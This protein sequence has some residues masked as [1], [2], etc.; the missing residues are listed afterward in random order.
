MAQLGASGGPN[1]RSS[2]IA[3]YGFLSD[4]HSAALL[5]RDGSVDWW[6]PERFDAPS[7]FARLLD[8]DAGHWSMRP[9]QTFTS[10]RSYVGRSLV[11]RTTF[12]TEH[13][14]VA[15]TDALAQQPSVRGHQLGQ[16]APHALIRVVEGLTGTVK[17]HTECAP[18]IEYGRVLPHLTPV[19]RGV[20]AQAGGVTLQLN[21][22]T[23][24]DCSQASITSTFTVAA[25]Q[26]HTFCL[27]YAPTYTDGEPADLD[28]TRCLAG[29]VEAWESW[30][31]LHN[32][33]HGHYAD[34]VQRSSLVIQGLTYQPSGAVV[35]AATTSLPEVLG[36]ERNYDYR[37]A[38]LRDFT[39][40]MRA[41]WIAACPDE[42]QALF[43]WV[44]LAT[45]RIDGQRLPIM[46]SVTGER[47]VSEHQLDHLAGFANSKP[48]R[49]GNEAWK[50]RQL[51]VL[52][53]I[54]DAAYLLKDELEPIGPQVR[55]LLIGLAEQA[56]HNWRA[57]DAG[58]W[59]ARDKERPYL[60]S[61][62]LCWVALD[63]AVKLAPKL[64]DAAK[65]GSPM[66]QSWATERDEIH[67]TVLKR[68]WN[69]KIGAFTGAFES[70]EL[71]ASVLLMPLVDF[72]P[73]EDPRMRATIDLISTKLGSNGL[74]R[75]WDTDPGGFLLCTY[76]LV[77]CLA[78]A[79]EVEKASSWF[80]QANSYA[81]DLGLLSEQAD[82]ASGELLG[83]FPQLFS[84]IGQINAA[85]RL[86]QSKSGNRA[87]DS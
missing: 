44:A 37:Y 53:E 56:K 21:A 8:P 43:Q 61:K 75:R 46:Y 23:P 10:Q 50:Q 32:T 4:C 73:A 29:T 31:Q 13:G 52:G 36:G 7:V 85:W 11:L 76:W 40:T 39:L 1:R 55:E 82:S 64:G 72:L 34:L 26:T 87:Q 15:V 27:S 47:D 16:Q 24:L 6:S 67:R 65:P 71:D 60:S 78:L 17:M 79:G 3:D 25:G 42:A 45:G 22:S 38:W 59:E 70:D 9:T 51:D 14:S 2:S 83:N 5:T 80:D 18:R 57:P 20:Q 30:A 33:F 84:H 62:V 12:Y 63:R 66:E 19:D 58:M 81:N 48:V 86:N 74:I 35:A 69:P 68:G 28:A 77:E 54:L 41:L 49:V